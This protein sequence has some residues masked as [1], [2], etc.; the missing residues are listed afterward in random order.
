MFKPEFGEDN[1]AVTVEAKNLH[2]LIRKANP[3]LI[4]LDSLIQIHALDENSNMKMGM[5][6]RR[7]R[8]MF[9]LVVPSTEEEYKKD[10]PGEVEAIP[11]K[12]EVAAEHPDA[13]PTYQIVGYKYIRRTPIAHILLHHTR[14]AA[15]GMGKS[16]ASPDAIRGASS[17]HS[18]ADLALTLAN[19]GVHRVSI[20][21][22]SRDLSGERTEFFDRKSED[23]GRPRLHF[24]PAPPKIER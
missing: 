22:S 11:I 18:E 24:A 7:I 6:M 12:K 23:N 4:I 1:L 17:I 21:K 20:N 15:E 3:K 8:K 5:L 16:F 14:K 10:L 13:K 19:V 9:S 2:K